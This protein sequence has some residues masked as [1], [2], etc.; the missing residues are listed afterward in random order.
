MF[1][2]TPVWWMSCSRAVGGVASH[3]LGSRWCR[4]SLG[5]GWAMDQLLP[6]GWG[7]AKAPLF[8]LGLGWAM[9]PLLPLGWDGL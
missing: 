9:A 4:G 5:W 2:F 8:P 6:L 3:R 1:G 7:W